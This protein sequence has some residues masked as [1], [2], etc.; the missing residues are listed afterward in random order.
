V[1]LSASVCSLHDA[2]PNV[3]RCVFFLR[4][5]AKIAYVIVLLVSVVMSDLGIGKWRRAKES[6]GNQPM[7]LNSPVLATLAQRVSGISMHVQTTLH[8]IAGWGHL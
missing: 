4:R 1:V 2:E 8:H 3:V 6:K 5:P 7:S